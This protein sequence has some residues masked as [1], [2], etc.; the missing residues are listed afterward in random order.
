MFTLSRPCAGPDGPG[1]RKLGKLWHY[2][3]GTSGRWVPCTV[4]QFGEH[5]GRDIIVPIG[6]PVKAPLSGTVCF[7][8]PQNKLDLKVGLGNRVI[9]QADFTV[10]AYDEE[11][12]RPYI[13]VAHLS[14]IFVCEGARVIEG[15]TVL[16]LSGDTGNVSGPHVHT[17][18]TDPRFGGPIQPMEFEWRMV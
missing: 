16:G 7:A 6:T 14:E 1:Y 9:F 10:L 15:Q 13:S 8:G 5:T 18:V 12:I 17:H 4:G 11:K 3:Q 2:F